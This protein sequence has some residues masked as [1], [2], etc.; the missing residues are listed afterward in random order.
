[1][2]R[3]RTE[4]DAGARAP[5]SKANEDGERFTL[6]NPRMAASG[7]Q[8]D[9]VATWRVDDRAAADRELDALVARAGGGAI[10]RRA[11][12][13]VPIAEFAIPREAYDELTRALRR[14]GTLTSD[15]TPE[16]L[17]ATVRVSLRITG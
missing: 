5:Q 10:A 14:L 1:M 11:E 16:A 9:V 15:R 3:R 8:A 17:P 12:S 6:S 4:L 13:E 7:R 2:E